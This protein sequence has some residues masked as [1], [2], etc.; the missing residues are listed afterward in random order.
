MAGNESSESLRSRTADHA[1]A[2]REPDLS[3]QAAGT[4]SDS[5][6]QDSE[7]RYRELFE[8]TG[9]AIMLLDDR[10]FMECNQATLQMFRLPDEAGFRR[11]TSQRSVSA[12]TA[13]RHGLPFGC[14]CTDRP[15]LPRRH[16]PL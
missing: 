13:G 2:D 12:P 15:G 3:S 16:G 10:G 8:S 6:M 9:D 14:G 5:I 4:V 1:P 7:I 11:Q